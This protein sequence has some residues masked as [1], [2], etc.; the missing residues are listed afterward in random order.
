MW[1]EPQ[2]E[3]LWEDREMEKLGCQT[4]HIKWKNLQKKKNR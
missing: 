4:T 2:E 3:E 1:E